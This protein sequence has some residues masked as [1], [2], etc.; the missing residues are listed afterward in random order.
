MR[1]WGGFLLSF[2]SLAAVASPPDRKVIAPGGGPDL[3]LPYSPG[4]LSG[5]FLYL[6]GALGLPRGS[7][8]ITGDI[9]AQTRQTLEN[10]A[11]VLKE[12]GMDFSNVTSVNV[13][14]RDARHFEAM[15]EVYRGY[16]ASDPPARATVEADLVLPDALVEIAMVAVRPGVP[17]RAILPEG[18]QKPAFPYSWGIL[19]GDTLFVS[20]ATSRDPKTLQP[21]PGDT[22]AQ[23]RQVLSNIGGILKAAGMDYK[24]V[25]T[26]KVFLDDARHFQAMN[27]AYRQFF[28]QA[29]PA[30]ATVQARLMNPAFRAEIQCVAT[31]AA[32]RAVVSA[33]GAPPSTS[34]LSPA[35]QAGER[36]YLSG[37]VGRGPD[38]Y[39]AGDVKAQTQQTLDNLRAT[40]KAAGLDFAN[41]VDTTVYLTDSRNF[42]AMNEI[43]KQILPGGFPARA[44]VVTPLMSPQALVEIMMVA[45][46]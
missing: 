32:D 16:F 3:G 6:A 42:G 41:V 37:M 17:R 29:P 21:V 45:A 31:K 22:G 40:L 11:A 24:D 33:E 18:W 36:L 34:P 9:Q 25:A 39:A 26:C 28:P 30:R 23:T 14:L 15:N 4:I 35:I 13:F 27:D 2:L 5:D 10:L 12:A 19:A 7:S 20:G 38:G 46:K 8:A 44:T 43:Y 1:L